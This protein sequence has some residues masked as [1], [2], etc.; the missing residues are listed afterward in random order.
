MTTKI[1][2]FETSAAIKS[3]I[4]QASAAENEAVVQVKKSTDVEAITKK[5]LLKEP[6]Q[7]K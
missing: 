3:A 6:L 5:Y 2:V 4:L 1:T 7:Q